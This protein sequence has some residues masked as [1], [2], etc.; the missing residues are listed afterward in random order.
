MKNSGLAGWPEEYFWRD[1]EPF[2]SEQWNVSTYADYLDKAIEQGSTSNGVFGAKV[3]MGG[4]YFEHFVSNLAQLPEYKD[5]DMSVPEL[6]S[7]TFPNLHYVWVTRR[8]KVRQAVSWL[9]AIQTGIWAWTEDEPPALEREPEFKFEAIDHLVQ[10]IVMRE[11]SWQEYFA[12]GGIGPSVV[13]YENL[14]PA[15]EETAMRVLEYLGIPVHPDLVFGERKM[16]KQ[17][18]EVSEEWVMRY[19]DMKQADWSASQWEFVASV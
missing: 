14:I 4:G 5:G 7:R 6:V 19:R 2:W 17:A 15:Y 11:A 18:D 8:N 13:V 12:A 3:M 10:E 1:D 16:R 9:K